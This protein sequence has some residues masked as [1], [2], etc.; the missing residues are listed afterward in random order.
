MKEESARFGNLLCS[1]TSLINSRELF[2]QGN[3]MEE[4]GKSHF[5]ILPI[6]LHKGALLEFN[7]IG[8]GRNR[9]KMLK[10]CSVCLLQLKKNFDW[11]LK[12]IGVEQAKILK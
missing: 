8:R 11:I 9:Y 4:V 2:C 5:R 3:C 7:V 1:G 6:M 12:I 10:Y